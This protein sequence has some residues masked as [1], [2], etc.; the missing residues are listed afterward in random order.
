VQAR[1]FDVLGRYGRL[2]PETLE[3][4]VGRL[5]SDDVHPRSFIYVSR[6]LRENDGAAAREGLRLMR[7]HPKADPQLR[8]RLA[9]LLK[10]QPNE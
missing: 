2:A 8:G 4:V 3:H 6:S 1:A 9:R 5:R 7:N 10:G